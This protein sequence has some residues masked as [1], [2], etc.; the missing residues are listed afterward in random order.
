MRS[1]GKRTFGRQGKGLCLCGCGLKRPRRRKFYP[2]HNQYAVQAKKYG[3]K[4][5]GEINGN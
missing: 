4:R 5:Y 3:A 1:P 2:G